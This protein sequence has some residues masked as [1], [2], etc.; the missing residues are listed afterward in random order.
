MSHYLGLLGHSLIW[1]AAETATTAASASGAE[2]GGIF[3]VKLLWGVALWRLVVAALIIFAGFL[4][5]KLVVAL[6]KR[7]L[8]SL[9]KGTKAQWDDD[10]VRMLPTPLSVAIQLVLWYFA[11]GFLDLP[12]EP[13]DTQLLAF[14]GLKVAIAV[15]VAWTAF[16]LVDV[17]TLAMERLS[18]KTDSKLDDQIVPLL[19]KTFKI[20]ISVTVFVMVVQNLGYSVAGLLASLGVGGLALALAAQDTVANFFGSVVIF[21]DRPFQVGDWVEFNGIEGDVEEVG[22][23]TTRIRRFDKSL[24]TV[25]NSKF[26]TNAI[27]NHSVR[28]KRRLDFTVGVTYETKPDQLKKLVDEIRELVKSFDGVDRGFQFVHFTEMGATSLNVRVYCFTE[29][30]NWVKHLEVREALM[31]RVM[32]IVQAHGLEMAFPTQT[33]YLRDEKWKS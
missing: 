26:S 1:A 8:E 16:R 18:A 22:F 9:A 3:S 6:F 17:F 2:E 20:L 32:E 15:T 19:R 14:Q 25:P 28:P 5:R 10:L 23:R 21:T 13:Y 30:I 27:T 4:S 24:I 11:L 31:L 29:T 7:S 12:S 33:L